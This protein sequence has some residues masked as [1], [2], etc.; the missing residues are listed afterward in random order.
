MYEELSI[1]EFEDV[2]TA[3]ASGV[4]V[5]DLPNSLCLNEP[6]IKWWWWWLLS[7]WLASEGWGDV[8][9]PYDEGG[10]GGA[11]LWVD[12]WDE[13]DG[14]G[15]AIGGGG[16]ELF[17]NEGAGGTGAGGNE[18]ADGASDLGN[19]GGAGGGTGAFGNEGALE[20]GIDGGAG[21]A[22]AGDF[23][24]GE[25]PWELSSTTNLS[26]LFCW[27]CDK[28]GKPP[29]AVGGGGACNGIDGGG[30]A[31]D[32]G[33]DGGGG[34]AD[35][36]DGA[37]P[38]GNGGGGGAEGVDGF[39][40]DGIGG[41]IGVGALDWFWLPTLAAMISA[42]LPPPGLGADGGGL[43]GVEAAGVTSSET[44]SEAE[45]LVG[46]ESTTY[47]SSLFF[48]ISAKNGK[49]PAKVGGAGVDEDLDGVGAEGA[50]PDGN[51]GGAGADF[52]ALDDGIG[53]GGGG[54]F[55]LGNGGG[56]GADGADGLDEGILG[57]DDP[58]NGGGP[59]GVGGAVG[60]VGAFLCGL[61]DGIEGAEPVG[62]GGGPDTGILGADPWLDTEF[63]EL[64]DLLRTCSL[65]FGILGGTFKLLLEVG[66]GGA[67]PGIG[68][69]PDGIGGAFILGIDGAVLDGALLGGLVEGTEGFDVGKFGTL[70]ALGTLARDG[71]F[72]STCLFSLGIPLANSPPIWGAALA[73]WEGAPVVVWGLEVGIEGGSPIGLA[74][75][76]E[77]ALPEPPI[78][79]A[80]LS[81]VSAFLSLAPFLISPR[82]A[83]LPA[84]AG[85]GGFELFPRAGGPPIGG[86][87]GGGAGGILFYG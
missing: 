66:K 83:S 25:E 32:V 42:R 11:A 43:F 72:V 81:L 87:G 22:G 47:E 65:F 78:T 23:G 8:G 13:G 64:V 56:G 29:A 52:G 30:G 24:T 2:V 4:G 39:D 5:D 55:E 59:G 7:L 62:N 1:L 50:P 18:G 19:E 20:L 77:D 14:D 48:W 10:G 80:L 75:P 12:E 15:G 85:A 73:S 17:G 69:A 67:I 31:L 21:G 38:V 71:L 44:C 79:G 35:G 51:G 3:G 82:R 61:D 26:S 46:T 76:P 16:A 49:P 60:I 57:A 27:I 6:P 68:G 84:I 28:N 54:A 86:G 37:D 53:G 70:G 9:A 74:A 41:A 63:I 45:K 36:I 40:I 33:N 58:G 34:G